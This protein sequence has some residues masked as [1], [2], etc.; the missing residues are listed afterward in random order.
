MTDTTTA[1]A[2]ACLACGQD[3][4]GVFFE[5][6][7]IP[8]L[9]NAPCTTRER[10]LSFPTGDVRLAFC[11]DCG[12]IFN[13]D[14]D[15]SR[16]QYDEFYENSLHYSKLFDTYVR[17]LANDL[18]SR[19]DL[20]G[21]DIIEIGCGKGDFLALLCEIGANRGVGFDPSY[22]PDRLQNGSTKRFQIVQELYSEAH[23]H[24]HC[25]LLCCRQVLEHIA[26][27][28][29]FLAG[30]AN[31]LGSRSHSTD[32]FFEVPNALYTLRHKGIWD[33]IYEHVSYFWSLPLRRLFERSG[34][35]VQDVRE[36][37][38][39]QYLCLEAGPSRG[40]QSNG[41]DD[42]ELAQ[43]TA[44]AEAFSQTFRSTIDAAAEVLTDLRQRGRRAVV[45][46]AGSKGVTF[47]N[48]FKHLGLLEYVV[49]INPHKQGR[50][51][52]GTGVEI[53]PPE[54]LKS[55]RPDLVFLMNPLYREEICNQLSEMVL[56]PDL[57]AV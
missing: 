18:V 40:P 45:W 22:E 44:E 29:Q 34:F 28:Q 49:D 2:T 19:L 14:F 8:V 52:P 9:A 39:G 38:G 10:A 41:Q 3:S 23:S 53:V 12:H 46:S 48:I 25:D 37:F 24:L 20:H 13:T 35:D 7:D 17:D 42:A 54:F 51:I 57:V 33:I 56:Y 1:S 30:L 26:R 43:V 47:L 36:S 15:P 5:L 50:F 32:V 6:K 21:K 27:P 4:A 31:S 16:L 55:F 11:P